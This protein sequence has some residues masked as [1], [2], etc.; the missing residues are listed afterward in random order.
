VDSK[1]PVAAVALDTLALPE[2]QLF[3]RPHQKRLTYGSFLA[4]EK[5]RRNGYA[6]SNSYIIGVV[7]FCGIFFSFID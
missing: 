6:K 4:N 5:L 2:N 1:K 3:S 7:F